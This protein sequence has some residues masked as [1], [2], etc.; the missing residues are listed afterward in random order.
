LYGYFPYFPAYVVGL[1]SGMVVVTTA[2][3]KA[4]M[5]VQLI[6]DRYDPFQISQY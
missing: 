3:H 6:F 4:T 1:Y 2:T 5:Q